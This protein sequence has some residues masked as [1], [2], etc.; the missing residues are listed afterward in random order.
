M[1][2]TAIGIIFFFVALILVEGTCA[3][4]GSCILQMWAD[5]NK[6]KRSKKC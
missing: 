2:D 1:S 3:P 4:I 5:H 6:K